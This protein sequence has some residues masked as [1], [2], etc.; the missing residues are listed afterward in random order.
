MP[1][2]LKPSR[3]GATDRTFAKS[4]GPVPP[5]EALFVLAVG[6]HELACARIRTGQGVLDLEQMLVSCA[7]RLAADQ[8]E[9]WT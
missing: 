3:S 1:R 7:V 2:G 5:Q 6:T 8:E 4:G 9:P